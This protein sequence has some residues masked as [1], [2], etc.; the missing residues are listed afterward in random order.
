[1]DYSVKDIGVSAYAAKDSLPTM[2]SYKQLP[3]NKSR[4]GE[5]IYE[6]LPEK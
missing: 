3:D 6:L 1:M 5:K 4:I 2:L